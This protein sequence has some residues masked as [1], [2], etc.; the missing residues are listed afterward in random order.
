MLVPTRYLPSVNITAYFRAFCMADWA[1]LK[2][3][4][5]TVT[6]ERSA[7]GIFLLA[8]ESACVTVFSVN[9]FGCYTYYQ[10]RGKGH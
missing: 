5:V 4:L 8:W 10:L 2:I 6:K 9:N 7:T 3:A 1:L